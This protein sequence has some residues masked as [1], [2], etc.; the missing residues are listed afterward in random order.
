MD[1]VTRTKSCKQ[2]I[3]VNNYKKCL[4]SH[5]FE[6]KNRKYEAVLHFRRILSKPQLNRFKIDNHLECGIMGRVA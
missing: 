6:L 3:L 2:R 1:L 5:N 4:L